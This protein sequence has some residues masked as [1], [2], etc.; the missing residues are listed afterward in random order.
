MNNKLIQ[1][2]L[3]IRTQSVSEVCSN[4][5]LYEWRINFFHKKQCKL[6]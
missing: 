3:A 1:W 5:E 4:C 2:N 6:D